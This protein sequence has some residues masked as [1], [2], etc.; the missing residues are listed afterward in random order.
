MM[1]ILSLRVVQEALC[2]LDYS[3][4]YENVAFVEALSIKEIWYLLNEYHDK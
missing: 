2:K 3:R 1:F 4:F